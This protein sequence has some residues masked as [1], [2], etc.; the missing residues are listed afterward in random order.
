MMKTLKNIAAQLMLSLLL[1]MALPSLDIEV[2]PS[3]S[4]K[5]GFPLH[6]EEKESREPATPELLTEL[7]RSPISLN[8]ARVVGYWKDLYAFYSTYFLCSRPRFPRSNIAGTR[9]LSSAL[10]SQGRLTELS[11]STIRS[12]HSS[13][14]STQT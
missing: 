11:L 2:T 9:G 6:L 4:N 13:E 1:S 12:S 5:V 3:A 14:A 10:G 8:L 7:Q